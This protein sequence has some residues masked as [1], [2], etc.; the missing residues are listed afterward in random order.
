MWLQSKFE[1][2]RK[3]DRQAKEKDRST[4]VPDKSA[5]Y[6]EAFASVIDPICDRIRPIFSSKTWDELR[7]VKMLSPRFFLCL[8]LLF[9]ILLMFHVFRLF[10]CG[11]SRTLVR[12]IRTSVLNCNRQ[13]IWGFF[14]FPVL[15]FTLH[16]G[17]S[18]LMT[19]MCLNRRTS[20]KLR[21]SRSKYSRRSRRVVVMWYVFILLSCPI[22][23]LYSIP[24][25]IVSV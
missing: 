9:V 19:C 16:S 8:P 14:A 2:L 22:A 4:Q 24:M 6:I 10:I 1:S 15:L 23:C 7:S 20:E 3:Q 17:H 5:R 21:R 11:S 12:N 25:I 18:K 13:L